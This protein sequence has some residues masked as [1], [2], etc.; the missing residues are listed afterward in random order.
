MLLLG[1]AIWGF[2]FVA[3][4]V[5]AEHTGPLTFNGVRFALGALALVPLLAWLDRSRGR[6]A[7]MGIRDRFSGAASAT[8][9][10]HRVVEVQ[11]HAGQVFAIF[12]AVR[13]VRTRLI[14]RRDGAQPEGPD[15][16]MAR[17]R[18]LL[19]HLRP[20]VDLSLIHI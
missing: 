6:S 2:A 10:Q 20:G 5:G 16:V 7:E 4:V 19:Q 17:N 13:E 11:D 14:L 18:G 12:T 1:A 3:Q 15:V 8:R 9:H